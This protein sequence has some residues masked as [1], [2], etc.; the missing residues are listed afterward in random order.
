LS[1]IT[2]KDAIISAIPDRDFKSELYTQFGHSGSLPGPD[3]SGVTEEFSVK[4]IFDFIRQHIVVIKQKGLTQLVNKSS[5][6]SFHTPQTVRKFGPQG[7][8]SRFPA[9]AVHA[10]EL[11]SDFPGGDRDFP[12]SDRDFWTKTAETENFVDEDD[13]FHQVNAMVQKTKSKECHHKGIGPD[14]KV[15]C[16][17]LGNPDTAKCGFIHPAKE[18]ELKGRGVSKSTPVKPNTVH[19]IT[20]GLGIDYA[21]ESDFQDDGVGDL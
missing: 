16:P 15:L 5:G 12:D 11:H 20:S 21:H 9:R 6:V 18:L 1:F 14:G 17:Y 8:P 2:I 3:A 19:N 13:E 4:D 10:I 7:P